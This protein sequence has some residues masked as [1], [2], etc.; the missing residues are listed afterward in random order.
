MREPNAVATPFA[1][2]TGISKNQVPP[3]ALPD[4]P[5]SCSTV[6]SLQFDLRNATLVFFLSDCARNGVADF[7]EAGKIPEIRKFAAFLRFYRLDGAVVAFEKNAGAIGFFLER[8]PATIRAQ[9][10][11]L[12]DEI[13]LAHALERRE[14]RDLGVIQEHLPRPAAAGRATLAFQENRHGVRLS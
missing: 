14:S 13:V 6:V 8:E 11:E 2:S 9:L 1:N 12:L 10:C 5:D 4:L 7:F 3:T